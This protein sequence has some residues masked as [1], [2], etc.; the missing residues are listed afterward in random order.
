MQPAASRLLGESSPYLLAHAAQPIPWYPWCDEA[1][2]EAARRD[3]PVFLSSGY[4]SCHWCHR[5]AA[6][7]FSDPIVAELLGA[8]FV[9]VKV[10]REQRPDV[11]AYYM[12]SCVA[13]SGEGGWPLTALL[14]PDRRPFFAGTYFPARTQDGRT[15]LRALLSRVAAL[16]QED[17]AR[18]LS[19]A[20]ELSGAAFPAQAQA[21]TD[22][23]SLCGA[24][25]EEL[26]A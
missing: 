10:D 15:G 1:F 16:W 21:R 18:I 17:R 4:A 20:D 12:R 2:E 3:V 19:W 14:L 8:H 7:A 23:Q 11:D 24:L 5:M 9:S 6:E 22:A 25:E 26:L 13:L